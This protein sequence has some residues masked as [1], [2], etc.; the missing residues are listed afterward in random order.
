[1]QCRKEE[2]ETAP[3]YFPGEKMYGFAKGLKNNKD[4][5]ASAYYFKMLKDTN[6]LGFKF[7]TVDNQNILSEDLFIL[8]IPSKKG[9][10][11]LSDTDFSISTV[12]SYYRTMHDDVVEDE[13]KIDKNEKSY[14]CITSIDLVKRKIKGEFCI[15]YV[16][17]AGE[18]TNPDNPDKVKFS[19][20]VIEVSTDK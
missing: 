14:F 8:N 2:L 18:K 6:T 10:Y 1:M 4:F 19:K 5:E 7:T 11:T 16:R 12:G 3:I 20:G 15:Y 17:N 13:Y 9:K